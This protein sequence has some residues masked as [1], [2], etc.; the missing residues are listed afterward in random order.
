MKNGA[1]VVN[2]R[3]SHTQLL[4]SFIFVKASP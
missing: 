3:D 2:A 1:I 4:L